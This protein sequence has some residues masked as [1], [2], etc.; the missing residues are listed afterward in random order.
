MEGAFLWKGLDFLKTVGITNL[1]EFPYDQNDC[2]RIPH[3]NLK[4]SANR[5][6]IADYRTVDYKNDMSVK[7]QIASNF[8]VV[9]LMQVDEGFQRLQN[10][11]IYYGPSGK[12]LGNHAMVVVGYDDTKNAFKVIN[13]WGTD[14]SSGGYGWISYSAFALRVIEAYSVQDIVISN[15]NEELPLDL[16]APPQITN[17]NIAV[18]MAQPMILHNVWGMSPVGN[19]LGMKINVPGTIFNAQNSQGQLIVRFYMPDGNPLVANP[20]EFNYRDFYGLCAAGTPVMPIMDNQ[21]DMGGIDL[22]IPYYALNLIPTNGNRIYDLAAIATFYINNFE[23]GRSQ[24]TP[25]QV[26]Y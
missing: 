13:S 7:S 14:W 3:E 24:F 20:Q 19:V 21:A 17:A 8:P 10:G 1:N 12:N 25:F 2:F 6:R 16:P 15:T 5:N 11:Q 9:F 23:K 18:N 26:R 22:F 4:Y